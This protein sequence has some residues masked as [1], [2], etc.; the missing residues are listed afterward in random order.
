M[1]SKYAPQR[2][3]L[4]EA[5]SLITELTEV[6][7]CLV[8]KYQAS[9]IRLDRVSNKTEKSVWCL[10]QNAIA[11]TVQ[12]TKCLPKLEKYNKEMGKD[13]PWFMNNI[14]SI[15]EK[16]EQLKYLTTRVEELETTKC[17]LWADNK[18]SKDSEQEL[19]AA[20]KMLANKLYKL[21]IENKRNKQEFNQKWTRY[22]DK[23]NLSLA[24]WTKWFN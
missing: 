23:S 22:A 8:A 19:T 24:W 13:F 16:K 6:N 14:Y 20:N 9:Q 7:R 21:E 10:D 2:S 17:K 12:C 4:D 1:Q 5:E 11:S 15:A 3:A 18:K